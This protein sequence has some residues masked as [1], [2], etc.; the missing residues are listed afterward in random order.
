[1]KYSKTEKISRAV[2]FFVQFA[3]INKD[4]PSVSLVADLIFIIAL[5]VF[6]TGKTV[7]A[8]PKISRTQRFIAIF[9]WMCAVVAWVIHTFKDDLLWALM[10]LPFVIVSGSMLRREMVSSGSEKRNSVLY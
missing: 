10:A 8:W 3:S 9:S 5:S 4:D 2:A 1:M 6:A 7:R